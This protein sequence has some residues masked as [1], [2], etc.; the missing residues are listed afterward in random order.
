MKK[1]I[2]IIC[3]ALAVLMITASLCA[4]GGTKKNDKPK[5]VCTA[6]SLYDFCREIAGEH[7][8]VL[9]LSG[10]SADTF[11]AGNGRVDKAVG[12]HIHAHMFHADQ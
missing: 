2:N 8:D 10:S 4:C 11:Y 3:A 9:L 1:T 7:A 12:S 5:I 6:L